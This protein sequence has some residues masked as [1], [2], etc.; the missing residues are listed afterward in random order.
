MVWHCKYAFEAKKECV[1][2]VCG[3]CKIKH[4][5]NGHKCPICMQSI[6]D[7]REQDNQ[8]YMPRKRR[9]WNGKAPEKFAIC[10]IEL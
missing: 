5:K 7:Y 1:D 8:T 10:E 6:V 4:N 2:G 9:N 3:D